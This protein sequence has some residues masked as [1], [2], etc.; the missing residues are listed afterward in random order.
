MLGVQHQPIEVVEHQLAYADAHRFVADPDARSVPVA[1]LLSKSYAA[2]RRRLIDP[3]RARSSVDPG[4]PQGQDT[5]YLTAID[6]DGNAV[7]FINSLFDAFGA[8]KVGGETGILL[9]NRGC[10][11][12]LEP[13]HPNVYGPGQAHGV[14]I[15]LLSALRSG[16]ELA[17]R[18]PLAVR[19]FLF[20]SDFVAAA[21]QVLGVSDD[22]AVFNVGAGAG[23]TIR[24]LVAG[25][26]RAAGAP[27]PIRVAC[28]EDSA[29]D[30]SVADVSRIHAAC[31]WKPTTSLE[32]GLRV[33]VRA[34]NASQ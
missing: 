29:G 13:G 17:L 34:F 1:G 11:F 31:G 27:I 16:Q 24:D 28:P 3:R 21:I 20:V 10:G 7:S 26:A 25:L 4:Q 2:E 14:L 9:H 5:V 19:D 6:T 23:T 33:T 12:S 8:K 15:A 18:S 22:Y 30:F 32:D